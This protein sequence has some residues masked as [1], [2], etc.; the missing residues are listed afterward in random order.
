MA[1]NS[2]V[3]LA[4]AWVTI[5][6]TT[7]GAE[8]AITEAIVGSTTDAGTTAGKKGGKALATSVSKTLTGT[9]TK[10][11]AA[12][13]T[14]LLGAGAAAVNVGMQFQS[15]MQNVA[16]LS[17][18]TGSE[19]AA[20]ESTAREFG[21]TTKFSAS[22]AADALG[23]MA[24][25]GWDTTQM[26]EGLGGVLNL[27]AASNM[28]LAEASDMVTDYLSAFGLEAQDSAY[29]ADMLAYAQGASNTS[30]QA[31]G[32]AYKNCAA[33]LNAAG[34]DVETT[35]SMLAMM[36]NQGLKGSEAGTALNAI[37][38]D[39]TAQMQDGS[40]AIGDTSVAV[41]DADGNFRDLTDILLDVESATDGMGDAE[42]AAALQ[43]TF[44]ADSTKGLNLLLN[45]GVGEAASFE[46]ALR[47]STGSAE[48]MAA[49][50]ND[51][52]TGRL[53]NLNSAM[54]EV[55]LKIF[56]VL[57]PAI[58]G[59]VETVNGAVTA[60]S[61]WWG[62]LGTGT[63]T[64]IVGALGVVAAIGPVL[65][66]I[67]GVVGAIPGVVAGLKTFRTGFTLLS[68]VLRAN[69]IGIVVTILG[70]LAAAFVT[71]YNSNEDFRNAVDTAW[72][73][74]QDNV[75][76]I[77]EGAAATI[78]GVFEGIQTTV[79]TVWGAIQSALNGDWTALDGLASTAFE[80]VKST[81]G[82]V[83]E[84]VQS[85]AG[86]AWE[87]VKTG[88]TT[89]WESIK[90]G[91]SE[92][93]EEVKK[94]IGTTW[95]NVKTAASTKWASIKGSLSSTWESVKSTA[96]TK[97]DTLKSNLGT[98]WTNVTSEAGTK[99][100]TIKSALTS[101]WESVKG[102][103]KTKFDTLKSNLGTIW[104]NVSTEAGTKWATIK[105]AL[106]STW[107]SVKSTANTKFEGLK[108]N[109][110][111]IWG[112][113]STA[114]GTAWG[115]ISGAL[116]TVWE[117]IKGDGDD[118]FGGLRDNVGGIWDSIKTTA[119][120]TWS[121]IQSAMTDPMGTA[122]STID[123]I[124]STISGIIGGMNLQ[125]PSI[126]LPHFW[127]N[128]G[129]APWGIAGMGTPPSFG[130][131]WYAKGG[132]VN[133][134]TIIGVGEAGPEAV[135]PLTGPNMKPFVDSIAAAVADR[136]KRTDPRPI[137]IGQ[138][139]VREEADVYKIARALYEIER[140]EGLAWS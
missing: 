25:A 65:L 28:D 92:K 123:G 26:T 115:T 137:S 1:D 140:E 128:G 64:A 72:Q 118:K 63:Q 114:A 133:G 99:W 122:K 58:S 109:L 121:G 139:V 41:M 37:M 3:T 101:T 125:L 112:N 50:M 73:W 75:G 69:P 55:G 51:S 48:A 38:R 39:I 93:F 47:G 136:D 7:E 96:K 86:T 131:D 5:I 70:T 106:T 13:T 30:A 44:T 87:T 117:S 12:L 88:L 46:E 45:A 22:Q 6:P 8:E 103:A 54:E 116:G 34:Q 29:F 18:A 83:W 110:G 90:G 31:L 49:T 21:S 108:S 53:A 16:A 111:T 102:T 76:P 124:A 129:E 60:F 14:P 36:A 57:E 119:G 91:A 80:A 134:A 104:G 135:V 78:G 79:G 107:E 89:T 98:V 105:S 67:G 77:F 42:R 32:M 71:A 52:L 81:I 4:K 23:Y 33:N 2:G 66:A 130:V 82:G 56:D 61:E 40:I 74:I 15:S 11:T 132:I 62:S 35:T 68:G 20:L 17:G 97:F 120:T 126:A 85:A 9:G 43:T 127:V 10:M 113:V 138:L 100:A 84:G 95:D 27:A 59:V 94:N 19:L 24:L